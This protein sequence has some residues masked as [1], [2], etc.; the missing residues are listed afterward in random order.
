[1]L[2][3]IVCLV[4]R[5]GRRWWVIVSASGPAHYGCLPSLCRKP[6]CKWIITMV[7]RWEVS[8]HYYPECQGGNGLVRL[9]RFPESQIWWNQPESVIVSTGSVWRSGLRLQAQT[10]LVEEALLNTDIHLS[11]DPR[12]QT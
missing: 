9:E 7:W 6:N 2:K 11:R 12:H 5:R 4:H 3:K 1:M 10:N 8:V